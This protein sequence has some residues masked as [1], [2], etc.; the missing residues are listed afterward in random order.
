MAHGQQWPERLKPYEYTWMWAAR[1]REVRLYEF[2]IDVARSLEKHVARQSEPLFRWVGVCAGPKLC[3]GLVPGADP[4]RALE[5]AGLHISDVTL[6]PNAPEVAIMPLLGLEETRC[7]FRTQRYRPVPC[8]V[9][10]GTLA[11]GGETWIG[12]CTLGFIALRGGRAGILTN[13]HCTKFTACGGRGWHVVQPGPH[14]GGRLPDDKIGEGPVAAEY[15]GRWPVDAAWVSLDAPHRAE[16]LDEGGAARAAARPP[17]D[18]RPG[19][20]VVKFGRGVY[21]FSR[22]EAT[23]EAIAVTAR[24]GGHCPDGGSMPPAVFVDQVLASGGFSSPGDSGSGVYDASMRPVGLLFAGELY[25]WRGIFSRAVLVERELGA[26]IVTAAAVTQPRLPPAAIAG[27]V[28]LL[29]SALAA[30]R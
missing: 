9:D 21:T 23:V 28:S 19:E 4:A 8:G 7:G 26:R 27:A 30:L 15:A 3:A 17:R 2:F 12:G 11:R 5:L 10:I 6:H 18:A 13:N 25:T 29:V 16:V 22:R 14:C 1:E 24:V 20:R